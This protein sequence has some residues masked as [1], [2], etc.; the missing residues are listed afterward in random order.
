MKCFQTDGKMDDRQQVH[1]FSTV[2]ELSSQ[3]SKEEK[4]P[5][6]WMRI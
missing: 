2:H 5:F 1:V 3:F 4:K 6:L